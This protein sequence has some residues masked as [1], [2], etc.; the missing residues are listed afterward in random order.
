MVK[1]YS[2]AEAKDKLPSVVHEA[3]GG[4]TIELLRRGKPVAVVVSLDEYERLR[5][6]KRG[7]WEAYQELRQKVDLGSLSIE[8]EEV[9]AEVRDPSPGRDFA[10]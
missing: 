8:P 5:R 2:I 4:T 3:E 10:W 7:F 1:R 6:G 9:F